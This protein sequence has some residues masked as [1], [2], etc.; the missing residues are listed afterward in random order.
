MKNEGL[1]KYLSSI[2]VRANDPTDVVEPLCYVDNSETRKTITLDISQWDKIKQMSE[3][4]ILCNVCCKELLQDG[5]TPYLG[6]ELC[7]D[8]INT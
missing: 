4:K 6:H 1:I 5:S 7:D 2:E 8:C 3:G